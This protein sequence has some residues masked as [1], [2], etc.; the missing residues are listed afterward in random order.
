M[1]KIK[2]YIKNTVKD[3]EL[4]DLYYLKQHGLEGVTLDIE[5]EKISKKPIISQASMGIPTEII[6]YTQH[7]VKYFTATAIIRLVFEGILS[8]ASYDGI[9]KVVKSGLKLI[10]STNTQK[11]NKWGAKIEI[12][13]NI[14][15]ERI[16]TIHFFL[17]NIPEN[18]LFKNVS[19]IE[20]KIAKLNESVG[21]YIK[22]IKQIGYIYDFGNDDWKIIVIEKFDGSITESL[23]IKK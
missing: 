4:S 16:Q 17:D 1:S 13:R 21:D 9:K 10:S 23:E 15:N 2:L 3:E 20:E 11:G 19:M 22:E 7:L 14:D 8:N 6:E 12:I 5:K 18:K